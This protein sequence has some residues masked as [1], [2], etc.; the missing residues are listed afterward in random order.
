[1]NW[2]R[3]SREEPEINFIPLID[4]LLVLLIFF[5]VAS[6]FRKESDLKIALPQG[7]QPPAQTEKQRVEVDI[8]AKGQYAVNQQ[9]LSGSDTES[10]KTA[11]SQAAAGNTQLPFIIRADAQT[12]HRAVVQ[13]LDAAGQLGFSRI[14]I[15]TL[16]PGFSNPGG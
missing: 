8:D 11:L 15:A 4:V 7:S 9:I 10:L 2:R 5:M 6:T 1:M 16:P 14:G 3:R 12:P 13:V